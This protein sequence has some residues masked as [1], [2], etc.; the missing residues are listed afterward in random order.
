MENG[1]TERTAIQQQVKLL[2]R[3]NLQGEVYQRTEPVEAQI[4]EALALGHEA[5][6]GRARIRDRDSPRFLQEEVLVYLIREYDREGRKFVVDDLTTELVSRCTG[7]V[8]RMIRGALHRRY[9]EDCYCDIIV[10]VFERIL[11]SESDRGDFAQV[12]F[13]LFLGRQILEGI[14]KY[15][16]EESRDAFTVSIETGRGTDPDEPSSLEIED[17][18]LLPADDLAAY[19][20]GLSILK[21]PYR[22]AFILRHYERWQIESDDPDEA[23]ICRYFGKSRK[24]VYNWLKEAEKTLRRWRGGDDEGPKRAA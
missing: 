4:R 15:Q 19:R 1:F 13:W 17:E 21:E 8:N 20:E 18:S 5:V 7:K 11:D 10:A 12:R 3:R 24:T 14:K 6:V 23:T 22:K 2:T 16:A 9:V